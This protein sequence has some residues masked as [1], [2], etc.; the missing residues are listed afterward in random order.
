MVPLENIRSGRKRSGT[1]LIQQSTKHSRENLLDDG[2]QAPKTQSQL[3]QVERPTDIEVGGEEGL[4]V[5]DLMTLLR[6][7]TAK[8]D[9]TR[10]E[11]R[12][13]F[14]AKSIGC[15]FEG[16]LTET[17]RDGLSTLPKLSVRKGVCEGVLNLDSVPVERLDR[18][19]EW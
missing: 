9:S 2:A 13:H 3:M 11:P 1:Q 4:E 5:Q 16:G 12:R 18:V 7:L 14:V 17:V 19:N 8:H 10:L 6:E 15:T